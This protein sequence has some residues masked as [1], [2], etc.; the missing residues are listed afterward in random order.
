MV[1]AVFIGLRYFNETIKKTPNDKRA[2][3]GRA[4]ARSKVCEY[5]E[6]LEDIRTALKLDP[7][8]LVILANKALNTYLNCSFEEGLIQNT[9]MLPKRKMP[10]HFSIGIMHV[11]VLIQTYSILSN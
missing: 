7:D 8:D 3:M 6:A 9:R 11:C 1:L 4:Y 5:Q 10:D 2:L